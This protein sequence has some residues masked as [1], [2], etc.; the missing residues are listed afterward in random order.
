M[1]PPRL[2]Q[3]FETAPSGGGFASN[4]ITRR[5]FLKRTGGATVASLVAW[6]LAA[7][8]ARA[9]LESGSGYPSF[10]LII[11]EYE[12]TSANNVIGVGP[13]IMDAHIDCWN[14]CGN[15]TEKMEFGDPRD[16]VRVSERSASGPQTLNFLPD[17][18]V[19]LTLHAPVTMNHRV[20]KQK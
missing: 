2:N 3:A 7:E 20:R 16:Y 1:L 10:R 4:E 9:D 8:R 13:N 18:S 12:R 5:T 14:Q 6:N 19:Q 15:E 17:G 11:T